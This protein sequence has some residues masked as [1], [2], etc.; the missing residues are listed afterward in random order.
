VFKAAADSFRQELS[1]SV[2]VDFPVYKDSQSMISAIREIAKQHPI[3]RSRM[4]V[5]CGKLQRFA[6]KLEPYFDIVNIF[7]RATPGYA[8][9]VWGSVRL[10]FQVHDLS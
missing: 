2:E 1:D 7:M 4:T 10:I 8:S 6:S 9:L 5:A 3:H